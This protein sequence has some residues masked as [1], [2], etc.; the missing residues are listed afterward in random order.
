[1][2]L[3]MCHRVKFVEATKHFRPIFEDD[4]TRKQKLLTWHS[5]PADLPVSDPE[6]PLRKETK[7]R[8]LTEATSSSH[9]TSDTQARA[10]TGRR[11]G[12]WLR[13]AEWHWVAVQ[14]SPCTKPSETWRVQGG[15]KSHQQK[16]QCRREWANQELRNSK[17]KK[18]CQRYQDVDWEWDEY[19]C[20]AAME[21]KCGYSDDPKGAPTRRCSRCKVRQ[22]ERFIAVMDCDDQRKEYFSSQKTW[23]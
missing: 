9:G 5:C 1:M 16:A 14:T 2:F 11:C 23:L 18:H 12:E 8:M 19:V 4:V 3:A 17:Q 20:F 10:G 7:T 21:E 22:D 13:T 15:E 6:L